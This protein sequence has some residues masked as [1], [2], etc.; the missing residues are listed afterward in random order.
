VTDIK[1]KR[2]GS[3]PDSRLRRRLKAVF[4]PVEMLARTTKLRRFEVQSFLGDAAEKGHAEPELTVVVLGMHRSGTSLVGEVLSQAGVNLGR[5]LVRA[6]INNPRGYFENRLFVRLNDK[7]LAMA[8][9]TWDHPPK[10]ERMLA[11]MH[12]ERL[13]RDVAQAVRSQEDRVWGWKDPRTTLTIDL[14]LPFLRN[15]RFVICRRDKLAVAK[16][17]MS[18]NQMEIAEGIE[19]ADRYEMRIREFEQRAGL[20]MLSVQFETLVEKPQSE[21]GRILSFVGFEGQL[22][23]AIVDQG[24]KH[25]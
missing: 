9:G 23:H 5:Q 6:R 2:T 10:P 14:Y 17:L 20:P 19:L 11:L 21:I 18:R 16:S 12:N 13:C 4:K 1:Q 25:F 24:L 8:R 22:S 15:P 3:G 7:L